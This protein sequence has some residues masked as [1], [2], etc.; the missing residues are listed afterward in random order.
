M[1][2]GLHLER[3]VFPVILRGLD[4]SFLVGGNLIIFRLVHDVVLGFDSDG[5]SFRK[6]LIS[7]ILISA[8]S[9]RVLDVDSQFEKFLITV[10]L[11]D[12][13]KWLDHARRLRR[14]HEGQTSFLLWGHGLLDLVWTV[15][16]RQ[17]LLRLNPVTIQVV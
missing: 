15:A 5:R 3:F 7:I 11:F 8:L 10:S 14:L 16:A 17:K 13:L 4:F 2:F 6:L 12:L 9:L 1:L